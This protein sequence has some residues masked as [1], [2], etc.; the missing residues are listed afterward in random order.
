MTVTGTQPAP[1][2]VW[3]RLALAGPAA[4]ALFAVAVI[5]FAAARTDGY[6]H[7][8]KA[9]S[10]LG[11][12][13]APNFIAFN[14]LGF[15]APGLLVTVL[16]WAL[17]GAAGKG[18]KRAGPLL[19]GAAELSL[20]AAAV[21]A[22]MARLESSWTLLHGLFATL[23]PLIWA[24]SLFFNGPLLRKMGYGALGRLTPWFA[25]FLVVHFVWQGVWRSVD[26]SWLLPGYGQRVGFLGFFLWPSAVGI[27]LAISRPE[28]PLRLSA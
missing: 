13:D 7:G 11:A 28:R 21:P 15:I 24:V 25:L 8:T 18:E 9:V 12:W 3:R 16:A 27:A 17:A 26:Q 6:T 5:G 14:V 20:A 1:N 23:A 19:L 2:A 10:E 4:G 22:D